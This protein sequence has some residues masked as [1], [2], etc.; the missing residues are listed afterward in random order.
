MAT[1]P[2]EIHEQSLAR[3][4]A[5]GTIHAEHVT[6]FSKILDLNYETDRKRVDLV[7]SLGVREVTSQSG[8]TGIP[9]AGGV[10]KTA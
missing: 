9:L 5:A 3:L 4:S 1:V 7:Q 6:T 10:A 2:T 8:Q